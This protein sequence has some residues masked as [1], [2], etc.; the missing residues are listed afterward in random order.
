MLFPTSKIYIQKLSDDLFEQKQVSVSVLRLDQLHA[1]VSGNK[2]FKLH[3]FLE[4]AAQ[5]LKIL[6]AEKEK[7]LHKSLQNN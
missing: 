1:I 2:L 5:Q 7:L 6:T 3:Y 4:L